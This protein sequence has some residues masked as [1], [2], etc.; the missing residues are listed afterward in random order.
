MKRDI[1]SKLESWAGKP[2]RKPLILKGARQVGKTFI[3]TEFGKNRFERC[4]TFNFEENRDI[5]K[6]FERDLNPPRIIEELSFAGHTPINPQ[7]DLVF[8]DEIQECPKALTSLKYFCENMPSLAVISAGSLLGIALSGESFPVGK[9]DFLPLYPMNF[10]EFLVAGDKQMLVD[11]YDGASIDS[12]LP[13]MAHAQLWQ[14]LLN[15]Y[16]VGGMPQAVLTY[17]TYAADRARGFTEA[18]K[19]QHAL[20]D[21][22]NKD[23][24]KHSGTQNSVHIVS[25]FENVPL[26]LSAQIDASTKRYHFNHVIPGKK[27]YAQLI[28][29]IDWLEKAGLIIKARICTRAEIPLKAF[30][31]DNFFKLFAFDIGIL[32]S[33]LGLPVPSIL[34]QDYGITKGYLAENFVAQ[35]F[36]AGGI[37]E[38]Y[39][40]TERNSEIEFL[41]YRDGAIVPV[42]VKAGHRTR[43]KSLQQFMIKYS[44]QIAIKLSANMYSKSDHVINLPLYLAGKLC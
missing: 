12:S 23:F 29:P 35:E 4:H 42:E 21:S 40:W 14:E 38:C 44:P 31:K 7:R 11:A 26:Q 28:G 15:Y 18:R 43:A 24:A 6:I 37:D 2:D 32:G 17:L 16:V 19:V 1:I 34:S 41:I 8:F 36:L 27:S 33:M 13:E 3:I 30:C 25:V 22:Y 9:V 10:R 39:S 20:V 5:H